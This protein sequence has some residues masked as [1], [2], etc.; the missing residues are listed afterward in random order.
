MLGVVRVSNFLFDILTVFF[1][2]VT[3]VGVIVLIYLDFKIL[4]CFKGDIYD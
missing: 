4:D 2:V 1:M 3:P